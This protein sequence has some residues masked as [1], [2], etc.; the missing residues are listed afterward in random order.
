MW[1]YASLPSSPADKPEPVCMAAWLQQ[2]GVCRGAPSTLTC[3]GMQVSQEE[4]SV[5][6][7]DELARVK[8][9]LIAERSALALFTMLGSPLK[10]ASNG[11]LRASAGLVQVFALAGTTTMQ[12]LCSQRSRL[13]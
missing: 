10:V 7:G 5:I 13:A 1:R 8:D 4:I 2:E 3:N 11:H 12:T 6:V 9:K